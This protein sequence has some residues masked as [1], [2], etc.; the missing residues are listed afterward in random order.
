MGQVG[1]HRLHSCSFQSSTYPSSG[2]SPSMCLDAEERDRT[3]RSALDRGQLR[4]P[5]TL[6][7]CRSH[8][9]GAKARGGGLGWEPPSLSHMVRRPYEVPSNRLRDVTQHS[10]SSHYVSH[11]KAFCC[12]PVNPLARTMSLCC[13]VV[14]F[15][16]DKV[17]RG[18]VTEEDLD[19]LMPLPPKLWNCR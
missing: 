4:Q 1:S 2:A 9:Q 18:N 12:F 16:L 8:P 6:R 19:T 11:H 17:S 3:L 5:S 10:A 15:D 14:W 13:A 7:V